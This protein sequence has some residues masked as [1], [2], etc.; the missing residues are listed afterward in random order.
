MLLN[1]LNVS[2]ISIINTFEL[3]KNPLFMALFFE[4]ITEF[5][6]IASLL[7]LLAEAVNYRFSIRITTM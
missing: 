6:E 5:I 3:N 1:K 4:F 7:I 2:N